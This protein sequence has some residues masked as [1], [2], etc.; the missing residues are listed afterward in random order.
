MTDVTR[1]SNDCQC[2]GVSEDVM[3]TAPLILTN[4]YATQ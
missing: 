3:D 1:Y 4:K 2:A